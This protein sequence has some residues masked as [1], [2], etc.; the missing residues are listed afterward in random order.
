M[1]DDTSDAAAYKLL[2]RIGEKAAEIFGNDHPQKTI[3][4]WRQEMAALTGE[5]MFFVAAR[6][7]ADRT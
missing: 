7:K 1:G 2:E 5:A 3:G 4:E 6:R